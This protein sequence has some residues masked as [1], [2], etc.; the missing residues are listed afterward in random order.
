MMAEI[1]CPFC[2]SDPFHYV[3][4]GV[5]EEPVAVVCCELGIEWFKRRETQPDTI[6]IGW[7]DFE[8]FARVLDAMRVL[9]LQP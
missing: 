3:N 8:R 2:G 7:D 4:N 5:G 1:T 9:G 6:E